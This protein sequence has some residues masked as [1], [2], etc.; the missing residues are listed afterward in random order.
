MKYPTS[1]LPLLLV[2]GTKVVPYPSDRMNQDDFIE[3]LKEIRKDLVELED[4]LLDSDRMNQDDFIEEL[5]EIRKELVEVDFLL[6]IDEEQSETETLGEL[7]Q[8]DFIKETVAYYV[9]TLE[10]LKEIRKELVELEEDF[11]SEIS[12]EK[13]KA[14]RKE[15][16]EFEEDLLNF[17]SEIVEEQSE[18]ESVCLSEEIEAHKVNLIFMGPNPEL[19]SE[20]SK[21]IN[22]HTDYD[23]KRIFFPNRGFFP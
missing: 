14:I 22:N 4:D 16:V 15:L 19:T 21:V 12:L 3:E 20:Y 17:M 18:E 6:E 23:N 5:K 9:T 13:L 8:D 7:N 2:L 11:L 1:V 10:Q